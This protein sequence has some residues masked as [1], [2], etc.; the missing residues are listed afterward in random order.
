M[1]DDPRVEKIARALCIRDGKNPD[2]LEAG[3]GDVVLNFA[4]YNTVAKPRWHDYADA[5]KPK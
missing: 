2:A 5:I 1:T 3:M 4:P